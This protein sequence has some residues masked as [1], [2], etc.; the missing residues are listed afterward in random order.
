MVVVVR[1]ELNELSRDE[2]KALVA[3]NMITM[4]DATEAK[5]IKEMNDLEKLMWIRS[6]RV[7]VK[8]SA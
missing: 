6:C 2:I 7:S 4:G 1:I 8:K 5:C 3:A